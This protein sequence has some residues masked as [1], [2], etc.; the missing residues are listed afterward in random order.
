MTRILNEN[1]NAGMVCGNRFNYH[2][3]NKALQSIFHFGN[4]LLSL[5]HSMLN[6]VG[7]K[8]LLNGLG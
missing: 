6:G 4:K 7:L 1:P 5:S 8:S 3:Q 2:P